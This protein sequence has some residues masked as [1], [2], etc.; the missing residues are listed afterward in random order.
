MSVYVSLNFQVLYRFF[1]TSSINSIIQENS[2][3]T[4]FLIFLLMKNVQS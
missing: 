3:K 4:L 2:C 1:A